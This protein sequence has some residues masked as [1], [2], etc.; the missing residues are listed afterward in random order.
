[1]D[2]F[3]IRIFIRMKKYL[4]L[5]LISAGF[6]AEVSGQFLYK[7]R[8]RD[9]KSGEFLAFVNIV[10]NEDPHKGSVSDIDGKFLYRSDNKI[11]T[12]TF[13]YI[14]YKTLKIDFDSAAAND[15]LLINLVQADLT[16][17]EVIIS[18]GENP[19]HRIIR[20]TIANKNR[21]D[22]EN[23]DAFS[24][25]S[26]NKTVCDFKSNDSI[27]RDSIQIEIDSVLK[28]G[29]LLMMESVTRRNFLKPDKSEE[30]IIGTRV[31]GFKHPSFATVATDIQPFSFYKDIITIFDINY[32]NPI[33]GGSLSKYQFSLKDTLY[34][35]QDTVFVISFKP[36]PGKNFEGLMGLLYINTN[37]FAIQHVI[38][39]P[40][41]KG[42]IDVKIQQLYTLIDN[43]QWFPNQLNF[44]LRINEYP[45]LSAG[46]YMKG[47]SYISQVKLNPAIKAG[48]FSQAS[49]TLD[50]KA[51]EHDST[52][53]ATNR[54]EK[55]D[56][57]EEITYR[58]LD[59]LGEKNKFERALKMMEKIVV[60]K[61]PLKYVD[62]DL[63]KLFINNRFEGQR[64]GLGLY[65]NET[66]LKGFTIGGFF[67]Y[68]LKDKQ[69]K[70]G[71]DFTWVLIKSHELELKG[72]YQNTLAEAGNISANYLDAPNFGWRKYVIARVDRVEQ[73]GFSLG[74]RMFRYLK[75]NVSATYSELKPQYSY[76]FQPQT[77]DLRNAYT[78]AEA[79]LSMRYAYKEKIVE[80]FNTRMSQG[81]NFPVF[82]VTY[83]RGLKNVYGSQFDYHK[84]EAQIEQK[85]YFKNVGETRFRLR[86]GFIDTPLPYGLMFTGEGSFD[87][88]FP[89]LL[90]N[91]FQ[92]MDPYEFLSDRYVNFFFSHNFGTLLFKTDK[93]KPKF[94][95]HHNMTWGMLEYKERYE[96]LDFLTKEKGFYESGLII[97]DILR[98]NYLNIA[99]LGVG[100]GVFYRYG[101]YANHN[102]ADNF[103]YRFSV[104]FSTK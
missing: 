82:S 66:W 49:I 7:G 26:Y 11:K 88:K 36:K 79:K 74:L 61:F 22:P 85:V 45:G 60:Y 12:I 19:A 73:K 14:G 77:A 57:K 21:N 43:K 76:T 47:K 50:A 53:W 31:S 17:Q 9:S 86:G 101:S 102:M 2:Y 30:T 72:L 32:L 20:Q 65:T 56:E 81:T 104:T 80:S 95:I 52:F 96:G 35:G 54:A 15:N 90:R 16:L 3:F 29:H 25:T 46:V 97:D 38:A 67:G 42:F 58:V 63:T 93:L 100:G 51:S 10:F 37:Y 33:A 70:Y 91:Y 34:Q 78:N 103:V 44:E 89:Y 23:A 18:A 98:F 40:Y 75:L 87:K 39:E 59:S 1:M 94:S 41:E 4:A 27:L 62:L 55:L 69:W 64:L 84:V 24:Y 92:S 5:L 68:G 83:S 48:D 6:S 71:G 13:S 8:V 28:G 99:Y